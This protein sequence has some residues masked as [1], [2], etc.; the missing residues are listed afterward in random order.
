MTVDALQLLAANACFLAA[1]LGVLALVGWPVQPTR[2]GSLGLAYIAGVAAIGIVAPLL[3]VAGLSLTVLQVVVI[4]MLLLLSG[5]VRLR[6]TGA[7]LPLEQAPDAGPRWIVATGIGFVAAFFVVL[8]VDL[9]YQP[10]ATWDAWQHWTPKARSFVLLD[11]LD[12][13]LFSAPAYI[14]WNP[15]YP[16]LLPAV[17]AID[18]RFM[19]MNTRILHLQFGLL[20]LGLVLAL[21]ELTRDRVPRALVWTIAAAVVWA[22]AVAIQT[23]SAYADVPLAVFFAL[24]GLSALRWVEQRD[25]TSLALVTLFAAAALA[26]K[27][28]GQIYAAAL[29]VAL[30][31]VAWRRARASA[32]DAALA[33]ICAFAVGIIPWRIWTSIQDVEG[34]YSTETLL[35]RLSEP[36]SLGASLERAAVATVSLAA[37][38][39]DPT[40]WL[41]IVPVAVA[42]G[43]WALLREGSRDGPLVALITLALGF[44]G[45]VVVYW[46]TPFP[47][48]WHLDRSAS[49]VVTGLVLFAGALT[50]P[51]LA[52]VPELARRSPSQS[53]P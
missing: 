6:L 4:S 53:A 14:W 16:L 25:T 2:L 33:G 17:E 38:L 20:L 32:R 11:G 7:P 12:A 23:A 15:D 27:M 10:L 34:V 3:L 46:L 41:V 13:D 39:L 48:E 49:R 35:R 50:A 28:E 51:L 8:A 1:G 9:W 18:F 43:G 26:T 44:G 45:L 5:L 42:A 19:G 30:V 29:F 31:L 47:L 21:A 40:S 37:E 36:D 52:A 24:A 22:P